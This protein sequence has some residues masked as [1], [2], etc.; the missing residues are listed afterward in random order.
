M[1]A[2]L[3]TFLPKKNAESSGNLG[4]EA[5]M[6]KAELVPLNAYPFTIN[7]IHVIH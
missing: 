3:F 5:K 2:C 4:K 6:K 1:I 7:V